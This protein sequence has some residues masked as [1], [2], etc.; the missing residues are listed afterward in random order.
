MWGRA[1]YWVY[2]PVS[3]HSLE[4][5]DQ[6]GPSKECHNE[7][8]KC[9][10][11]VGRTKVHGEQKKTEDLVLLHILSTSYGRIFRRLQS[12]TTRKAALLGGQLLKN[13]RATH[14]TS[15]W[16]SQGPVNRCLVDIRVLDHP[17]V[18]E[19]QRVQAPMVA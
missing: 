6:L 10:R 12:E 18:E 14:A 11:N 9:P 16:R 5:G 1:G 2:A 13:R 15:F 8:S 4:G 19:L 7:R 3:K 17:K